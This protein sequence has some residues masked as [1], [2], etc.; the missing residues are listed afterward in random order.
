MLIA[1]V[2]DSGMIYFVFDLIFVS[3][4]AIYQPLLPYMLLSSP[5]Q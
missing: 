5:L 4:S 3:H 2:A 1:V